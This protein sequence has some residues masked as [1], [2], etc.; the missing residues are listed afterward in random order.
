MKQ[1]IRILI[2]LAACILVLT[3]CKCEHQ[4]VEADCD[5]A[6]TCSLCEETEGAPLGHSWLAATCEDPKTCENCGATEGEAKGHF[7][8]QAT[9]EVAKT[10]NVCHQTEGDPLGHTWEEATTERP[11]TCSVCQV[12]EGEPLDVDPRF[13]TASTKELHGL[14]S[15]DVTLTG[16]MLELDDYLENLECT[17]FYYFGSNGEGNMYIEFEDRFA[18]LDAI[19]KLTLD[20]TYQTY[21]AMGYGMK[22]TDKIME[23]MMGMSTEEY[24]DRSIESMDMEDFFGMFFSDFLYYVEDGT[25]YM[26]FPDPATGGEASWEN[27]FESSKYT[28]ENGVLIMEEDYLDDPD[29]PLEWTRV[30]E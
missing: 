7:W 24:V 16:E 4:W 1:K 19:K 8:E 5:T 21:A 9:C 10:C 29:K 26:T 17:L 25:V 13:T 14:W 11:K 23:E 6:K 20:V 18:V 3:G 2:L 30:E 22:E 12:T 28:L 27:D 15:C